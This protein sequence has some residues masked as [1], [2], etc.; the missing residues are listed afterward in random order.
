MNS[1]LCN[2]MWKM[3][4]HLKSTTQMSFWNTALE[5]HK[6][7]PPL[8][9]H[10]SIWSCCGIRWPMTDTMCG[11]TMQ[12]PILHRMTTHSTASRQHRRRSNQA[13][14]PT[15]QGVQAWPCQSSW[16]RPQTDKHWRGWPLLHSIGAPTMQ[17]SKKWTEPLK[18]DVTI[19]SLILGKPRTVQAAHLCFQPT[20][21][22]IQTPTSTVQNTAIY[23]GNPLYHHIHC[24][25][26]TSNPPVESQNLLFGSLKAHK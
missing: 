3:H 1:R 11:H 6:P 7:Q 8:N 9:N 18:A 23:S 10:F 16:Y 19:L 13:A 20:T 24:D 12:H 5:Q 17:Q 22:S 4:A 15:N 21:P 14:G 26:Y 2:V 25:L